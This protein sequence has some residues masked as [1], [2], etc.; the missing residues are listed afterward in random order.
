MELLVFLNARSSVARVLYAHLT[1][2]YINGKQ[3]LILLSGNVLLMS[4]HRRHE[5]RGDSEVKRVLYVQVFVY[6]QHRDRQ[7]V[8]NLD[9]QIMHTRPQLLQ[10]TRVREIMVGISGKKIRSE[11]RQ[12]TNKKAQYQTH[13]IDQ[14]AETFRV[15]N[16]AT[17]LFC[18]SPHPI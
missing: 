13:A 1:R 14:L 6:S 11:R 7:S 5:N 10:S 4:R 8:M 12:L 18:S 2:I 9:I 3:V 17:L 15:P 16:E